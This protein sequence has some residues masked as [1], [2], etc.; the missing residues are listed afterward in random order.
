MGNLTDDMT[1]LR[2]EIDT[3]RSSR[4][5]L[6]HEL[7]QDIR[8]LKSSVSSLLSEFASAHLDMAMSSKKSRVAFVSGIKEFV[9]GMKKDITGM[10]R[11]MQND[12]AGARNAWRG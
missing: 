3:L 12:I 1:R 2:E 9:T 4:G 6:M 11:D 8:G 5:A 7:A 10:K